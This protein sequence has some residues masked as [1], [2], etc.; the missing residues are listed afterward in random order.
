MCNSRGTNLWNPRISNNFP[1]HSGK[2]QTE[3]SDQTAYSYIDYN[4]FREAPISRLKNPATKARKHKTAQKYFVEFGDFVAEISCPEA[5][6]CSLPLIRYN[7][8]INFIIL[9][10]RLQI[11][12]RGCIIPPAACYTETV[13][14]PD[15][16]VMQTAII[17]KEQPVNVFP[18]PAASL[19]N[20]FSFRNSLKK[21]RKT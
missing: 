15:R 5:Q 20:P 10:C 17:M 8:H 12:R 21:Y 9:N 1:F 19:K 13:Q 4:G 3:F 16:G 6:N 7:Q 2:R 11:T 18:N 14:H